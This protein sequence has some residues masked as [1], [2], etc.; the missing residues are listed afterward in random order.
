MSCRWCVM[1]ETLGLWKRSDILSL[2]RL[3]EDVLRSSESSSETIN[4]GLLGA[5][6]PPPH[7]RKLTNDIETLHA[8]PIFK[9]MKKRI[10][11]FATVTPATNP[12]SEFRFVQL[13]LRYMTLTFTADQWR[14]SA[15]PRTDKP[16]TAARKAVQ[17]VRDLLHA[18]TINLEVP[19]IEMLASL[20]AEA[21]TELATPKPTP[22]K[23][24]ALMGLAS[25]LFTNLSI[26][27]TKL[28]ADVAAAMGLDCDE[29]TIQ[30]YLR[31]AKKR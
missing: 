11:T 7:Q 9:W 13:L 17:K 10:P 25:A 31:E 29:R 12:L 2:N 16:R 26:A 20:L 23:E 6:L 18:G 8:H 14:Q 30:R 15:R 1:V 3:C 19:K 21:S 4:H 27:D 24:P 28:L 5:L 22:V